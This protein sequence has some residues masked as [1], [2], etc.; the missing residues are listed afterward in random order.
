MRIAISN[1]AWDTIEDEAVAKLLSKYKIDAIDI[2][3]GKYFQ[4]FSSINKNEILKVKDWWNNRGIEI[5]GMQ[6]ILFGK[7]N[8]NLFGDSIIQKELIE[9]LSS[10]FFIASELSIKY[11][12]FG[13]PKNRDRTGITDDQVIK[14]AISFFRQLGNMAQKNNLIIC[15]EPNPTC[16]GSNFMTNCKDTS[17]IVEQI[18][19]P[20]IKMQLDTG[21]I[22][23]NN[24]NIELI[25]ENSSHLIGHI[26]ASEPNLAPLGD[27][28]TNHIEIHKSLVKFL[29]NHLVT[30]EML[31]TK[32]EPHLT[33]IE[34]SLIFAIENYM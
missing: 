34:R 28:K 25:L 27:C 1:I 22:N 33:S 23:I 21:A 7:P 10:V 4:N 19:H 6:S 12:V 5:Y 15:L 24:E 3:P 20:A 29:P 30:I 31:A 26:H 18:D 2:A 8:L 9:H 16:Y 17:F 13:S 14:T 11:L 32:N